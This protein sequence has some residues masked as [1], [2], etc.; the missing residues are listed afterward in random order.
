MKQCRAGMA[1][2]RRRRLFK[3][4]ARH[5]R[6]HAAAACVVMALN[7]ISL[8]LYHTYLLLLLPSP[9]KA[10]K[11]QL[12]NCQFYHRAASPPNFGTIPAL[13]T[14]SRMHIKREQRNL[15]IRGMQAFVRPTFQP[16]GTTDSLSAHLQDRVVPLRSYVR[17][18]W[19]LK[20]RGNYWL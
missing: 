15:H 4:A 19:G 13:A 5:H 17:P 14:I 1:L 8:Y 10:N 12:Q 6:H 20:C 16:G 9:G 2:N 7:L 3:S 11:Q 18:S